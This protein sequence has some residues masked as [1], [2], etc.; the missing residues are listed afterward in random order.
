MLKASNF[1]IIIIN[2]GVLSSKVYKEFGALPG[3]CD[4]VHLHL[5]VHQ[6]SVHMIEVHSRAGEVQ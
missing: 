2:N 3:C 4:P 5:L 1:E 6:H